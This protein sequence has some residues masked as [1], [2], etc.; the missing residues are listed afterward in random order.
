[1][2]TS[3][4]SDSTE[5]C[6][7]KQAVEARYGKCPA[8]PADF[9]ELSLYIKQTTGRDVSSDTLSRLWGYKRGYAHVRHSVIDIMNAYAH[10]SVE[11]DFIYSTAI[12]ADDLQSGDR[13]FIAWLPDR[14]CTLEYLGSYHWRIAEVNHS[15]LHIGDT[16]SCRVIA[17]DQPLVVDHLHTSNQIYDGYVIGGKNGLTI[18]KKQ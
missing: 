18:V 8:S 1:M 12:K 9:A 14:T 15:K 6:Q 4:L 16:F 13:V 7:A 5:V 10:A 3:F 11:S 2:I 17:K